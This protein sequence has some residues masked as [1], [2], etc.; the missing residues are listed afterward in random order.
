M[1]SWLM[2]SVICVV[3]VLIK[4]SRLH[5][6]MKTALQKP[7]TWTILELNNLAQNVNLCFLKMLQVNL[8]FQ[9]QHLTSLC[10]VE[11]KDELRSI[12]AHL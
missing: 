6:G 12:V 10:R 2:Y 9:V 3:V 11:S 8:V 4:Y 7:V 5:M 1:R